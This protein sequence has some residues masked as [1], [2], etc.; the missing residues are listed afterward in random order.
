[1]NEWKVQDQSILATSVFS[2]QIEPG[3][4]NPKSVKHVS[5]KGRVGKKEGTDAKRSRPKADQAVSSVSPA[6]AL[7]DNIRLAAQLK[8]SLSSWEMALVYFSNLVFR[9]SSERH[10]TAKILCV[11][12]CQIRI[13]DMYC[14]PTT[15]SGIL[16][17]V[18]GPVLLMPTW[19]VFW[20][21]I[22]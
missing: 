18:T 21:G 1:M 8:G 13:L 15:R 9:Q 22:G 4:T 6:P 12:W 10:C 11:R 17:L 16:D 14:N 5:E 3:K 19:L 7:V 2:K 20:R